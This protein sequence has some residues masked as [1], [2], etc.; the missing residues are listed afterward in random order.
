MTDV[1]IR[2]KMRSNEEI[3]GRVD[4]DDPDAILSVTTLDETDVVHSVT[5]AADA[6]STWGLLDAGVPEGQKGWL[7]ERFEEMGVIGF[8]DL[9]DT[10]EEYEDLDAVAQDRAGA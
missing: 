9:V 6:I 5:D 2:P 10:G 1:D 7:R 4:I 3:I 8:E